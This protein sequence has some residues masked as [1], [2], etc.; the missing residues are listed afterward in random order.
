MCYNIKDIE[1][2]NINVRERKREI[3]QKGENAHP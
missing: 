1:K 2:T 3:R